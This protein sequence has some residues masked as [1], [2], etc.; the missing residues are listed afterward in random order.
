MLYHQVHP[1]NFTNALRQGVFFSV[2]VYN[3]HGLYSVLSSNA[4]Y[5]KSHLKP[6]WIHDGNNSKSDIEYQTSITEVNANVYM[7][8]NCP[9][10]R[11]QWGVES[12]DGMLAQDYIEVEYVANSLTQ[13]NNT[14]SL[15][16][17]QVTLYNDESYRV[18]FQA[19]DYS[20]EVFILRSNGFTVTTTAVKPG[21]VRDGS[22]PGQDLNYQEP[23]NTLWAHWLGFGDGTPEQEIAFY[24][25]A[26][27]S[28]REYPSTRTDISPFV[29][30]GLN[31][32]HVFYGLDLVPEAVTYFITVRAHTVSGA[33]IDVTSNGINVGYQQGIIPGE[34][35]LNRYQYDTTTVNV[36]WG[37]F[38]SDL[39]IR[40]YEWALGTTVFSENVL[41][42]FC[43]DTESNF[44]DYFD[45]FGFTNVYLD[46]TATAT[47]LS[48]E[49]NTT[50]YIVL[51]VID[52]AKKCRA[53]LSPNGLTIDTTDPIP[54][55]SPRSIIVGPLESRE[56]VPE[57]EQHVVYIQPDQTIDVTWEAFQDDESGI[58]SYKVGIF[59][60]NQ[61]C[62]N[63]SNSLALI[64]DFVDASDE[65]TLSFGNVN[66]QE[67]SPYV[68]VVRAT[69][70]AGLTSNGY[71]QPIV[72]DSNTVTMGTVKDG[73]NWE[74]DI[75][76]QSDLSMLSAVFTHA[77]LSADGVNGTLLENGP[78]PTV[79]FYDFQTMTPPWEVIS[80]ATVIGHTFNNREYRGSQ[81][82]LSSNP[83]GVLITTFNEVN[84]RIVTGAYETNVQLSNGGIVSVDIL[85]AFGT[86]NLEDNAVTAVTFINSEEPN[87]I[88]FFEPE[89]TNVEFPDVNVFGMQIYRNQSSQ[90]VVLW[91]KSTNTLSPPIYVRQDLAHINLTQVHTYSIDFQVN[92]PRRRIANLYID[93]VLEATLEDLPSLSDNT[94]ILLH[95]FNRLG[96]LLPYVSNSPGLVQ[97]VQTIFSNVHLPLGMGHLCDYGKPFFSLGSPIVEFRAAIGTLPGTSDVRDYEVS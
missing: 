34:I 69:N 49:H 29:N 64:R 42:R 84:E 40:Q 2:Q 10:Q 61:G 19:V 30:V 81:V 95:V 3:C 26:A 83:P 41:E 59:E 17:D 68:V 91:T 79:A 54:N 16:S 8:V 76:Y 48:L 52:Q 72:V 56:T 65:R 45:V 74:S 44:T 66:L 11:A 46:T 50:Y 7:G 51:R 75:V 71:S 86:R 57:N 87:V 27:G 82:G 31:T 25:V 15:T 13:L 4:V 23:T 80:S 14:F 96:R 92:T 67:G 21:L 32:S 93:G 33:Y 38:E 77:K 90:S 24:K 37:E 89:L 53:V 1:I 28:D 43:D 55:L 94:S 35:V 6:S 70:R 63:N 97:T 36:Y 39:P 9:I 22:I 5:I 73:N 62:G 47:G 18:L 20:G 12:V 78:C 85:A 88:P 60:Q 58:M